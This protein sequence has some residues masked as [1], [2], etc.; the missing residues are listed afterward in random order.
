MHLASQPSESSGSISF[1]SSHSSE[2][3]L[4]D[5][6]GFSKRVS[7]V[8]RSAGRAKNRPWYQV[9]NSGSQRVISYIYPRGDYSFLL[10]LAKWFSTVIRRADQTSQTTELLLERIRVTPAAGA[11]NKNIQIR[12]PGTNI[13]ISFSTSGKWNNFGSGP[14]L[15]VTRTAKSSPPIGRIVTVESPR[16][17]HTLTVESIGSDSFVATWLEKDQRDRRVRFPISMVAAADRDVFRVGA[18][19]YWQSGRQIVDGQP[20]HIDE[21]RFRR[22]PGPTNEELDEYL[23]LADA[24]IESQQRAQKERADRRAP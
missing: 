11:R 5:T 15:A 3:D 8:H 1:L 21:L 16:L 12:R 7:S 14:K 22:D 24:A 9:H 2:P 13:R 20:S 19:F 6:A 23:K 4:G 18:E 10:Q 17:I